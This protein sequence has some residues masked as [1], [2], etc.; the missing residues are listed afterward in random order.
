VVGAALLGLD[1][2]G[3]DPGAEAT[4]RATLTAAVAAVR[5]A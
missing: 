1:V 2:V 4:V 5:G 3:A